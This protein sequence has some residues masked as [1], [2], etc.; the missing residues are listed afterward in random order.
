MKKLNTINSIILASALL[1]LT[2]HAAVFTW[3]STSDTD[4]NNT[5]NWSGG[6]VPT[7]LSEAG[8][9]TSDSIVF[10]GSVTPTSNIPIYLNGLSDD[11]IPMTFNSGGSF[12][13]NFSSSFNSSMWATDSRTQ[14][15]VGDGINPFTLDI[16]SMSY[17]ARNGVTSTYQVNEGSTLNFNG[18]LADYPDG[19]LLKQGVF[20]ID[21]GA[22]NVTGT[23]VFAFDTNATVNFTKSNSSFTMGYDASL[24]TSTADV[25]ADFGSVFN[26]GSGLTLSAVDNGT[27]FTITA[28]PEPSSTALF[29]LSL[30]ALLTRRQRA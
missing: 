9:T 15:T 7:S 19:D 8:T 3:I 22:I 30:C 28:I 6:S 4:W 23:A 26:A 2:S 25:V 17:F 14:L 18:N 11:A 27:S 1:P 12:S 29:G 10:N 16:N 24:Y 21:G 20:S 13:L 5:A